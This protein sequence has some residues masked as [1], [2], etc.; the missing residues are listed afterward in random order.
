MRNVFLPL[1]IF[2]HENA[3]TRHTHTAMWTYTHCSVCVC[4]HR[5]YRWA[6]DPACNVHYHSCVNSPRPVASTMF[7]YTINTI[8]IKYSLWIII[9]Y[10]KDKLK[11]L[12]RFIY[13]HDVTKDSEGV[14]SV[15]HTLQKRNTLSETCMRSKNGMILCNKICLAL[16]WTT[17]L[18][19]CH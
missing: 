15:L 6:C 10:I 7:F 16:L 5:I 1:F 14:S 11:W 9:I 4:V 13:I 18:N 2:T 19:K 8:Y 17:M 3:Q 12:L